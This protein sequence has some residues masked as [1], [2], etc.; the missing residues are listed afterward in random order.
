LQIPSDIPIVY[1]IWIANGF[2][3]IALEATEVAELVAFLV[4]DAAS[5]INGAEIAADGGARL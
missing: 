5:Y 4:S 3:V 2:S 1:G